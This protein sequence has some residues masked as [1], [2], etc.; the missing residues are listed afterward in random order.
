MSTTTAIAATPTPEVSNVFKYLVELKKQEKELAA[1]IKEAQKIAIET[2]T[3]MGKTGQIGQFDGA[4]ITFKL[5]TVKPK[6]TE[7]ACNA[8]DKIDRLQD[9]LKIL[10]HQRLKEIETQAE[11]INLEVAAK[12]EALDV[13]KRSLLTN[14]EILELEEEI[15]FEMAKQ[16]GEKVGQIAITLP[17]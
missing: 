7:D 3:N 10:H 13:E 8:Q 14:D 2:A 16:V 9:A 17:K 15:E 5:V 12:L 4:K 1:E 11:A 6:L